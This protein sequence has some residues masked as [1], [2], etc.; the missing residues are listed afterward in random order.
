M[1]KS[2]D[3][4]VRELCALSE[5]ELQSSVVEPLLRQK[6]FRYVR[7]TS[8]SREKGKD[9]VAIKEGG[10]GQSEFYAIQIKKHKVNASKGG[11]YS[12]GKLLDQLS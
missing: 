3:P 2:I 12:L 5:Y 6:G 10:F 7:D 1:P 11:P 4:L 9:L 8:G